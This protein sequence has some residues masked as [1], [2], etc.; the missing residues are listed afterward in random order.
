[1][2]ERLE[3]F[4]L[5]YVYFFVVFIAHGGEAIFLSIL[6]IALPKSV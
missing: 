2:G 4:A 1:M 3:G 5:G 6:G